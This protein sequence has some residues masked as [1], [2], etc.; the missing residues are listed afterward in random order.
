MI[1]YEPAGHVL[2]Q[3]M[4]RDVQTSRELLLC[5]YN[6]PKTEQEFAF[7]DYLKDVHSLNLNES[8][9]FG[10]ISRTIITLVSLKQFTSKDAQTWRWTMYVEG[11]SDLDCSLQRIEGNEYGH[12]ALVFRDGTTNLQGWRENSRAAIVE[13]LERKIMAKETTA[14]GTKK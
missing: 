7:K 4:P 3:R 13:L 2:L 1:N 9:L 6:Y 14:K 11:H 5:E 12:C 10:K 8:G